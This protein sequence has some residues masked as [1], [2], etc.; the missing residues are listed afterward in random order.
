MISQMT[1]AA[2]VQQLDENLVLRF[3]TVDDIEPLAQF[4]G[5]I[6]GDDGKF[7]PYIAQWTR[8]FTSPTHPTCGP[9][10]VT[11]VEDTRTGQIV[12]SM[13]SIPQM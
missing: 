5:R 8:E 13:C 9:G 10:N 6:H 1:D 3:A 4:N 12:S 11:I 7:N 2:Y